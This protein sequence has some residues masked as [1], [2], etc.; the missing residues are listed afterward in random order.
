M[1][2]KALH[3]R[4]GDADP[5][6][7]QKPKIDPEVEKLIDEHFVPLAGRFGDDA[8]LKGAVLEQ[9][10]RLSRKAVESQRAA[11]QEPLTGLLNRRAFFDRFDRAL[12][13]RKAGGGKTY[14]ISLDV[15]YLKRINR[16]A[17]DEGGDAAL[18]GI[19]HA[20]RSVLRDPIDIAGRIGGDELVIMLNDVSDSDMA[21]SIL[22]RISGAVSKIHVEDYDRSVSVSIGCVEIP[23]EETPSQR[24]IMRLAELARTISK[25]NG[26][27]AL[28]LVSPRPQSLLSG[29]KVSFGTQRFGKD[30]AG[31]ATYNDFIASGDVETAKASRDQCRYDVMGSLDRVHSEIE[32]TYNGNLQ[33]VF[34]QYGVQR[35]TQLNPEQLEEVLFRAR[36]RNNGNPSKEM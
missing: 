5:E 21:R 28:T 14:M 23:Q 4:S 16:V 35:M 18:V 12:G 7:K 31:N 19:A 33:D 2:E 20:L 34:V 26:R 10:I 25:A 9:F 24:E 1:I 36:N 17:G 13:S 30:A 8:G 22:A 11:D 32:A 6:G 3:R 29:P 27:N 15:D